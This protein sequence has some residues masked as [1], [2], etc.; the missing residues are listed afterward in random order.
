MPHFPLFHGSRDTRRHD[1]RDYDTTNFSAIKKRCANPAAVEKQEAPAFIPSSYIGHLARSHEAQR[2]SGQFHAMIIDVDTGAHRIDFVQNCIER[3]IGDRTVIIYSSSSATE[4]NPKWRGIIPIRYPIAGADYKD[5]QEALFDL[6]AEQ[7]L[8]ADYAMARTGQPVY[9][10]NVPP[11]RRNENGEPLFYQY[12]ISGS[13]GL[14]HVPEAVAARAAT[15]KAQRLEAEREAKK[16]ALERAEKNRKLSEASG[17]PSIIETFLAE[18]DLTTLMLEHGW[19]PRGGDWFASPFSQSKG[20]S[21]WVTD[22]RA[23]SFTTSDAGRIGKTTD[24]GWTTYDAWDVYVA[25]VH[26]N[27]MRVALLEYRQQCGYEQRALHHMLE[28]WGLS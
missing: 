4:D 17:G 6:L 19:L 5:V 1:G 8:H 18:N 13:S 26:G 20:R 21:V 16:A 23:V 22:Q 9:L 11:S 2:Q 3:I 7:G 14:L 27:N 28:M 15:N 10:P 24:N 25:C 12:S